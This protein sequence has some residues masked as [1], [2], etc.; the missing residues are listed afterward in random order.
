MTP[1][2]PVSLSSALRRPSRRRVK[3]YRCSGS[4]TR[5]VEM[6][7]SSTTGRRE[8]EGGMSED[9]ASRETLHHASSGGHFCR[10]GVGK[11]THRR[12]PRGC[13]SQPTGRRS[14]GSRNRCCFEGKVRGT[15]SAVG[16]GEPESGWQGPSRVCTAPA[17]R[18]LR[19]IACR[20]GA[21]AIAYHRCGGGPGVWIGVERY[22]QSTRHKATCRRRR[23]HLAANDA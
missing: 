12:R 9:A 19:P 10:C 21:S 16:T 6:V 20:R 3:K 5:R 22:V 14:Q 18:A 15:P 4:E 23:S 8:R 2:E 13:Q 11:M 7:M 1:T 17:R